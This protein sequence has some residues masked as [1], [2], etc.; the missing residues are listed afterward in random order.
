MIGPMRT[1]YVDAFSGISGDMMAG[2]LLDAG[3]PAEE[4]LERL[5]SLPLPG[6]RFD[7]RR[8]TR[9]AFVGTRF[10]VTA[11]P[12]RLARHLPDVE[13][14]VAAAA[15]PEG[16]KE[17]AGEVFARIA[18]AEAAAH[19][20]PEREVHFHEVG[21]ADTIADV[22]AACLG[23]HLL[24]IEDVA[25]SAVELGSGVVACAHGTIPVPA[26]GALGALLGSRV[27]IGGLAGE[28]TTPTGAA[29]LA[30]FAR[31][32]GE[33]VELVPEAIGYGV[34][35]RE[36]TDLP[37]LLRVIVG[38]TEMEGDRVAVLEANLD[39]VSGETAGYVLERALAEGALDAFV[40]PVTMKKG[41]PG[42]VVTL[43][44][45]LPRRL[46]LEALLF[47]ET[48]TLGVRRHVAARAKLR[49]EVR[50]FETEHGPARAKIRFG[51]DGVADASA[52]F[53]DARRIARE[54]GIPLHEAARSIEAAARRSLGAAAE[55][56][57]ARPAHVHGQPHEHGHAHDHDHD[58]T[59]DHPHT[60]DHGHGHPHDHPH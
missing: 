13:R 60:H 38:E 22:V 16:V 33:P 44:A 28:R 48:P 15:V 34:G 37:N 43:L 53:E 39:D 52:E 42:L 25:A 51:L 35:S 2:A 9:G 3:A 21:A 32:I 19:G 27:R 7:V 45:P 17:R 18:R 40:T 47:R 58:H 56:P 29:L 46:A 57:R 23:I 20:I 54:R 30:T 31:S 24:G 36:T 41:R 10:V 8:E 11:P 49:R 50:T 4:L 12:E 55:G 59:H 1:L 6:L 5:R 14:V 26:P